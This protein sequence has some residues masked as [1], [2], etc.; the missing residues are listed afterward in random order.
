MEGLSR[1]DTRRA[2]SRC[3]RFIRS[4]DSEESGRGTARRFDAFESAIEL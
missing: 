2:R 1:N 4:E 3:Y